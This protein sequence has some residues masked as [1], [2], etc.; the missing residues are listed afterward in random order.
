M[1]ITAYSYTNQGGREHNEDS[2]RCASG[3]AGSIFLLADGLGGHGCG[4]VASRMAVDSIYE[5]CTTLKTASAEMLLTLM[6]DANNRI[7]NAQSS[8]EQS[9]M[10]TT[11]VALHIADQRAAWAY[12][13]DSRLYHFSGGQ[14]ARVTK[15]HSVTYRKY[16][17]GEISYMDIYHDDDRTRLMRV[18]GKENCRPEGEETEVV[19]GDAFLL[20]SDGFWE[21]VYDEEILID[22]LKSESPA[23]W[24]RNMLLRHIRRAAPGNDNFSLITVF[25]EEET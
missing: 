8:P 23:Q 22:F 1:R 5:G 16:M 21:Y 3:E 15:D 14:I 17:G 13:G 25:V 10:R 11:A 4:E 18:L 6:N 9:D 20:C 2:V 12:A 19:P 7:L 24:A